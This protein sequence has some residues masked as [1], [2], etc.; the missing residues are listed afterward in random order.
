MTALLPVS[1]GTLVVNPQGQLLLI[2]E[3][4][5]LEVL[6]A[7]LPLVVENRAAKP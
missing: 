7:V 2:S 5:V 4:I 6:R 1:C 3:S